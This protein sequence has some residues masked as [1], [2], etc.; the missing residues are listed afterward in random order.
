MTECALSGLPVDWSHYSMGSG[1][2]KI[3]KRFPFPKNVNLKVSKPR[4]ENMPLPDP[5]RKEQKFIKVML[6]VLSHQATDMGP[7]FL[8][9]FDLNAP[10]RHENCQAQGVRTCM[11]LLI[12][13]YSILEQEIYTKEILDITKLS[14][15]VDVENGV[16]DF[17]DA[18]KD[19]RAIIKREKLKEA[20]RARK[21]LLDNPRS[22]QNSTQFKGRNFDNY[23]HQPE[24][25]SSGKGKSGYKGKNFDPQ[26]KK[27]REG[28]HKNSRGEK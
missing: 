12:D 16:R 20:G 23:Q 9:G 6:G 11:E 18:E 5:R 4:P 21:T 7:S 13:R 22:D 25:G 19:A 28:V 10:I 15:K 8:L 24:E 26:Y 27:S 3:K 1:L 2:N 14:V 17:G